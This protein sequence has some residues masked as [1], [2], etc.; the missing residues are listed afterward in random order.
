MKQKQTKDEEKQKLNEKLKKEKKRNEKNQNVLVR[1]RKC[2]TNKI[3]HKNCDN[4]KEK[5][6]LPIHVYVQPPRQILN[7]CVWIK[8]YLRETLFF[9]R[10]TLS[11]AFFLFN[12]ICSFI[13]SRPML[14]STS[15]C[16]V[17]ARRS[18]SGS[19]ELLLLLMLLLLLLLLRR[20][21]KRKRTRKQYSI[22]DRI[23]RADD[24]DDECGSD[25]LL[26]LLLRLRLCREWKRK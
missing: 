25:E 1:K 9:Q 7:S 24:N 26:L 6:K 5:K 17:N 14:G 8:K 11:T 16:Y 20:E 21:R 22:A 15:R 23:D 10:R 12:P 18:G 4:I 13:I 2:C 19:D 3:T